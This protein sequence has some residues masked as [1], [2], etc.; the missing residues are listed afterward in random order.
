ML[1]KYPP[2]SDEGYSFGQLKVAMEMEGLRAFAIKGNEDVL[3]KEISNG[4]P[5]I[6]PIRASADARSPI[7][8]FAPFLLR[9]VVGLVSPQSN[10]FVVVVGFSKEAIL[11][12]DPTSGIRMVDKHALIERWSGD[13]LMLVFG[14]VQQSF[15]IL[16]KNGSL[17]G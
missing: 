3:Y 12:A 10:H 11:L 17:R 8:G 6:I 4:R 15:R 13:K 7:G 16:D 9:M 14:R 5:V 2:V 1:S